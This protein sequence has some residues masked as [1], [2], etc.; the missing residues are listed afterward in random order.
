MWIF[1]SF[2]LPLWELQR[3][4]PS[5]MAVHWDSEESLWT[6]VHLRVDVKA[7][8]VCLSPCLGHAV[9]TAYVLIFK[10]RRK[11]S[12]KLTS[13]TSESA[14]QTLCRAQL[15]S[16]AHWHYQILLQTNSRSSRNALGAHITKAL[17]WHLER[18]L[19]MQTIQSK[20]QQ[21]NELIAADWPAWHQ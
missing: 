18:K 11:P 21:K 5:W 9:H 17:H 12:C 8:K 19:S 3:F 4:H 2:N 13:Y 16:W 7:M 10:Y 1:L 20:H 14:F 6:P 15:F